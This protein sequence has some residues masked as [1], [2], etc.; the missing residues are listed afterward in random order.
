LTISLTLPLEQFEK[1]RVTTCD[2]RPGRWCSRRRLRSGALRAV[3]GVALDRTALQ[4]WIDFVLLAPAAGV[5][6]EQ[7]SARE[8]NPWVALLF[9][10]C[11][12][13]IDDAGAP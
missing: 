12:A 4:P 3:K 2:R 13:A 11:F 10:Q 5:A 6:C 7:P 8:I 9:G 1:I